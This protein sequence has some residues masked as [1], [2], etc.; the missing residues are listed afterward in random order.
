MVLGGAPARSAEMVYDLS[1]VRPR[2]ARWQ[3]G[4]MV[5]CSALGSAC[6][7]TGPV[8]VKL[9]CFCRSSSGRAAQFGTHMRLHYSA[10]SRAGRSG[11]WL[12]MG[13]AQ[14]P[15]GDSAGR[16]AGASEPCMHFRRVAVAGAASGAGRTKAAASVSVPFPGSGL[17]LPATE[18]LQRRLDAMQLY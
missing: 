5:L 17:S 2:A 9:C 3:D 14:R 12:R 11:S 18:K 8:P 4:S 15:N 13:R 6:S 10:H 16:T 7:C 1:P